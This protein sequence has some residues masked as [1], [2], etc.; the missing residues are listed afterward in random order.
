MTSS[1]CLCNRFFSGQ[2]CELAANPCQS[3]PCLNNGICVESPIL[4]GFVCQC[5]K[6]YKGVFCEKSLCDENT[7]GKNGTTL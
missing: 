1:T 5:P 6:N 2:F 3:F 7:C 4:E